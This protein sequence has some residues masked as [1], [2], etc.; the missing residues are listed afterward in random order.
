MRNVDMTDE[1]TNIRKD[2]INKNNQTAQNCCT[3]L[4][5][6][7][8]QPCFLLRPPGSRPLISSFLTVE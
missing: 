6:M 7:V 8:V 5:W 3:V 2:N 1:R 4:V